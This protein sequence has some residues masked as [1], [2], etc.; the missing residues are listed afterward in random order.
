MKYYNSE[1][2]IPQQTP[3]REILGQIEVIGL[4]NGNITENSN[5][6]D[7]QKI[8]RITGKQTEF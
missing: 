6:V 7:I 2:M 1:G 5:M 3:V 4:R 8:I